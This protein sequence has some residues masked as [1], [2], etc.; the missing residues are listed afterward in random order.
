MKRRLRQLFMIS[1]DSFA[2]SY[3]L[4]GS[5]SEKACSSLVP[6]KVINLSFLGSFICPEHSSSFSR[7]LKNSCTVLDTF[8]QRDQREEGSSRGV[9]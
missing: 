2:V 7:G 1:M 3:T 4:V 9:Q 5:N 6:S 8:S